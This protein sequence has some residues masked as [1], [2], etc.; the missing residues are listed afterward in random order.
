MC[1]IEVSMFI[2]VNVDRKTRYRSYNF[3]KLFFFFSVEVIT[4]I[5]ILTSI[6]HI[7][8]SEL[9]LYCTIDE[10]NESEFR[11]NPYSRYFSPSFHEYPVKISQLPDAN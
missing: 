1:R 3:D 6:R 9:Q 4:S 8:M 11:E 5:N 10:K 7:Y 2:E